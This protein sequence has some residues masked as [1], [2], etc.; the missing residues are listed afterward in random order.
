MSTQ[1]I[2]EPGAPWLREHFCF[3]GLWED[4][5]RSIDR[6]T[7][8]F[9]SAIAAGPPVG[10]VADV[11]RLKGHARAHQRLRSVAM[12]SLG[13]GP[14]A[15]RAREVAVWLLVTAA[16]VAAALSRELSCTGLLSCTLDMI[17]DFEFQVRCAL[18][19]PIACVIYLSCGF[20]A[21]SMFPRTVIERGARPPVHSWRRFD[22]DVNWSIVGLLAGTPMIQIIHHASDK[23]GVASGMRLYKDPLEYGWVWAFAQVPVYLVLWDLVF[24][25]LHRFVLH[26]PM[27]YRYIHGSHHAFRPPTAWAGIAVGPIDVIFEG[28]LPYAVPLFCGLPFHEYTVNA[29]N[30]LLT[31]HACVLHS[32]CHRQY[33]EISG[34][35]GWLMISPIGHNMHHNSFVHYLSLN[36]LCFHQLMKRSIVLSTL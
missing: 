24:Y 16:I 4:E 35:L 21:N 12:T 23:Y 17:H 30:A 5:F 36:P 13:E 27:L 10:V 34:W 8:S 31:L 28:I 25:V 11:P 15:D 7:P 22:G 29:V 32:A 33:G 6:A 2:R 20:F 26:H 14:F 9:R 3:R 1:F 18:S 19:L